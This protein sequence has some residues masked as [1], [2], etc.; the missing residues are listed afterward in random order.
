MKV[1]ICVVRQM[2]LNQIRDHHWSL[3]I[4]RSPF[5]PCSFHVLH[6]ARWVESRMGAGRTTTRHTRARAWPV[7]F[8]HLML[9]S[10]ALHPPSVT[11]QPRHHSR[12]KAC[13]LY[14]L[15]IL[16]FITRTK[17]RPY[18]Y[19]SCLDEGSAVFCARRLC[20]LVMPV[21]Y[22]EHWSHP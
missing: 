9:T 1:F 11:S 13:S 19:A 6:N 18:S 22:T 12:C 5:S 15:R 2:I 16:D 3:S 8:D 14:L 20:L 4:T 21:Q 10:F 17:S 7:C